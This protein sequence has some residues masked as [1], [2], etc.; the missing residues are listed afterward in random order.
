M[1]KAHSVFATHGSSRSLLAVILLALFLF[2]SMA[3][4]QDLAQD[5]AN[6]EKPRGT[7]LK[8]SGE[9]ALLDADGRSRPVSE[10][11]QVINED[12]TIV[13]GKGAKIVVRF[14]DGSLSVLNEES[15]LRVEKTSW[16]S[17]LGG[18]VY[19]SFKKVFGEQRRVRT[20]S[21]TIGIRGT[22]FIIDGTSDAEAEVV[23]LKQGLLNIESRG[24]AFEIH[25]KQQNAF[26]A[27]R[28]EHYQAQ[29]GMMNEF[30]Q[31]KQQ[32]MKEFVEYRRQ[33]TLKPG[34]SI[35]LRAYRLEESSI[36]ASVDADF[37]AFEQEAGELLDA[38][39]SATVPGS[40]SS[41]GQ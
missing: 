41:T 3:L 13:T 2:S 22:T 21:A 32:T 16:Y 15:R 10:P 7:V 5:R 18:K 31:Y 26:D 35:H 9:V 20:P 1:S 8:V 29:R 19:F 30:D 4:A 12:D 40:S 33:F 37:E 27:Y 14:D 24:P 28:Q 38:F 34:R 6:D 17:W 36:S 39:R 11:D 25:R 23:S